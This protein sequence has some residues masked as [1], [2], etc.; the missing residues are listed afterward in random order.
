MHRSGTS[1]LTGCLEEC[2]LA[3][4]DVNRDAPYNK[5]GNQEDVR[6]M[7]LHDDVLSYNGGSWDRPPEKVAWHEKHRRERDRILRL[8]EEL[9]VFGIKDP[10]TLLTIEGWLEVCSDAVFVG[11]FRHPLAVAESLR[12]RNGFTA[13]RSL[14]LWSAYNEKLV[15][16]ARD[17]GV[18]L[19]SFDLPRSEYLER[20]AEMA[21][22]LGLPAA[23]PSLEFFEEALRKSAAV[24]GQDVPARVMDLYQRLESLAARGRA[25]G[26]TKA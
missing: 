11:T 4:G 15:S 8:Y 21:A 9:P 12:A 1:C 22:S 24:R 3:L 25:V 2:G 5:K 23:R 17:Y 14:Q 13:A 6:V 20:V 16:L 18:G 10:R 26:T 19:V 7:D